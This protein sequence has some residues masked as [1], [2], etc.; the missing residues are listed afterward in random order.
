MFNSRT[1]KKSHI[2]SI[3]PHSHKACLDNNHSDISVC[4]VLPIKK[5]VVIA[6]SFL[7][8]ILNVSAG[9]QVLTFLRTFF[10]SGNR[11]KPNNVK[12]DY[13]VDVEENS[14]HRISKG[15]KLR[16]QCEVENSEKEFL[17][18]TCWNV[19]PNSLLESIYRVSWQSIAYFRL[20]WPCIMNLGWRERPSRC[21]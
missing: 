19:L 11:R 14:S 2:S 17:F 15:W 12:Q 10:F 16:H 21:N 1:D 9:V 7:V 6:S 5:R 4:Q 18:S 20:L 3:P 8:F 13:M